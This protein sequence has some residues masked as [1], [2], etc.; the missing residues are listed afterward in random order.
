MV[1]LL[2]L[3]VIRRQ[4]VDE[5]GPRRAAVIDL[6]RLLAA[7]WTLRQI[8]DQLDLMENCQRSRKRKPIA[9]QIRS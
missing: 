4:S 2:C 3:P 9:T 5:S 6:P 8:E 1:M 7:G